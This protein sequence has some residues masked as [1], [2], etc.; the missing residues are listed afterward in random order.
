MDRS[1]EVRQEIYR[2]N[3]SD[4]KLSLVIIEDLTVDFS[5]FKVIMLLDSLLENSFH[6]AC[7]LDFDKTQK[8]QMFPQL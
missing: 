2:K 4:Q 1:F 7:R 8:F 5:R 3:F 6:N